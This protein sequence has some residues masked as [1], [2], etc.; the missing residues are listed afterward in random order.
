M[1]Q[2]NHDNLQREYLQKV[3][4]NLSETIGSRYTVSP[5]SYPP[6]E[7]KQYQEHTAELKTIRDR[8]TRI[9][10]AI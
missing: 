1:T 9:I 10:K 8:I 5:D 3:E 7:W 6:S 4:D 2:S